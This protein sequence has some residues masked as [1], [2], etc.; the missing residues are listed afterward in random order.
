MNQSITKLIKYMNIENFQIGEPIRVSDLTNLIYN[1]PG[2]LGVVDLQIVNKVGSI[3]GRSYSGII[4]NVKVNTSKGLL[5][6]PGGGIF[7]VKFPNLVIKGA[8]V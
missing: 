1:T 2:V 3:D 8:I 5:L 4:H 6:S 7:E